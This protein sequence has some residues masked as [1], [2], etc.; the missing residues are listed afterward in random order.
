MNLNCEKFL[1]DNKEYIR[2]EDKDE[3]IWFVW[4][5]SKQEYQT[6]YHINNLEKTY[7]E[8]VNL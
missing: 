7:L 4:S 1:I 2:V 8:N 5:N 3:P 6:V